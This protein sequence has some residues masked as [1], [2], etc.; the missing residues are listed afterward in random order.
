M[1]TLK[2]TNKGGSDAEKPAA[3]HRGLLLPKPLPQLLGPA[4]WS[5][6]R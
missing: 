1:A 6:A 3:T 4:E 5:S 2:Q